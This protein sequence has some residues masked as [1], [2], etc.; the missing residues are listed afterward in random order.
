MTNEELSEQISA[1]RQDIAKLT[2]LVETEG[3]RC[4]YREAIAKGANN[5]ARITRL[6]QAVLGGG[7]LGTLGAIVFAVGKTAGWW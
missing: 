1:T 4:P 5:N 6:E 7:G 2:A 3:A